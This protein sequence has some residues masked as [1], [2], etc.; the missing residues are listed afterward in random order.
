MLIIKKE[1]L[2]PKPIPQQPAQQYSVSNSE[3]RIIGKRDSCFPFC[4]PLPPPP[5]RPTSTTVFSLSAAKKRVGALFL[6]WRSTTDWGPR[7]NDSLPLILSYPD[8][9]RFDHP[10]S[11]LSVTCGSSSSAFVRSFRFLFYEQASVLWPFLWFDSSWLHE[12]VIG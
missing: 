4:W 6:Q 9:V 5:P 7:G 10:L 2:R 11:C 12:L 3:I 8:Q 1:I